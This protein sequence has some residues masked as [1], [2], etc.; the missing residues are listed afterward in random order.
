MYEEMCRCRELFLKFGGHPMAA[1]FS[2]KEQNIDLL[3]QRL[4]ELSALTE[5]QLQPKLVID[6]PMP[7]D[8]L[9]PELIR[10]LD[11]L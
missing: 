8:Y 9:Y 6:V 1:G 10:Q 4:N 7:V 2:I 5:E 3:R 11:L